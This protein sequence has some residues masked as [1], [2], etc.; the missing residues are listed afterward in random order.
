[1]RI[2]YLNKNPIIRA[3]NTAKF[4]STVGKSLVAAQRKE[5][6]KRLSLGN[7]VFPQIAICL[8]TIFGSCL[9]SNISSGINVAE[10]FC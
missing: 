6:T 1:M 10:H 8:R 3:Q 9:R 4:S 5:C 2:C 7:K